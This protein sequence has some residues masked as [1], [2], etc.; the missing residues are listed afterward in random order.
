MLTANYQGN[1]PA[2]SGYPRSRRSALLLGILLSLLSASYDAL[3]DPQEQRA[4][5]GLRLFRTLLAADEDLEQKADAQGR[6]P[7]ALI[8]RNDRRMAEEFAAALQTSGHGREQGKIKNHPIYAILMDDT[9]LNTL[10]EQVP[11]AI[12]LVQPLPDSALEGVIRYGVDHHRIVFSPF[13]GHVEKG[14]LAGL[15]IEVRVLP[16]INQTILKRSGIRLKN[17]LLK[18]AKFHES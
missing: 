17:L 12:Y 6:L 14:V 2:M 8:Y 15:A 3:G 10:Q 7:L 13:E 9:H 1:Q 5:I 16:Y 18:V 11:A 4:Q